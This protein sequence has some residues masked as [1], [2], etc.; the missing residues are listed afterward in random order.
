MISLKAIVIL[1]LVTLMA[2][3]SILLGQTSTGEVNGTLADPAGAAVATATVK[4]INQA[5]NIETQVRPNQN[6]Y[7][8]FVN[9]RPGTYVLR[10]E[11]QGFKAAQVPA[12]DVGVN[13]TV[14]QNVTLV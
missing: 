8:T 3:G 10:V 2:S 5:T 4:L 11:A 9:V 14:T 7:F 6:G 12:F 13:Q 1:L